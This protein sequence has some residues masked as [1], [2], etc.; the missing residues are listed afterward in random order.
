MSNCSERI[1]LT[2]FIR[3]GCH[4][5][6][7][8]LLQLQDLKQRHPFDFE[9]LDVDSDPHLVKQYG[10]LVPVV[11]MGDEQ[12]CHYYLDQAALLQALGSTTS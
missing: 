2:V 10:H 5:C 6:E 12:I 9:T 11:M 1:K 7:D 4:L 3:N 8:L